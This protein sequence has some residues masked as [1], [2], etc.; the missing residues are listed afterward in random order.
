MHLPTSSASTSASGLPQSPPPLAPSLSRSALK[1]MSATRPVEIG[2]SILSLKCCAF[3]R[4]LSTQE[5]PS[6]RFVPNISIEIVFIKL[7]ACALRIPLKLN[8]TVMFEVAI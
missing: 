4:T 6:H 2:V 3:R 5:V 7:T 8:A 1:Q